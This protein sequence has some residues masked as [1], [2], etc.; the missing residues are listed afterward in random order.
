MWKVIYSIYL[1]VVDGDDDG[2]NHLAVWN[3]QKRNQ[4]E[5]N[6][7]IVLYVSRKMLQRFLWRFFSVHKCTVD[8]HREKII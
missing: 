6:D 5:G 4:E 2:L 3:M 8:I 7:F 1:Y